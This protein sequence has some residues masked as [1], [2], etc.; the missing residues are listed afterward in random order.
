M[1]YNKSMSYTRELFKRRSAAAVAGL[2]II[3]LT[4]LFTAC[5]G[6]TSPGAA[7]TYSFVCENGTPGNGKATT[8]NIQLCTACNTGYVLSSTIGVGAQC[9]TDTDNDS[10]A[11]TV[12]NCPD[13]PNSDQ[14]FDLGQT[15]GRACDA[16]IDNDND[17]LIEIWTL[18]QLHNMRYDLA[19]SSYKTSS[20]GTGI[21]T[22]ASAT[23]PANCDDG[24][25]ATT[26]VLCGYELMQD[27]DFDLDGD[28]TTVNPDGTLDDGDNAVPYFVV[29]DGGWNPIGAT[30]TQATDLFSATFNGNGN[31]ISNLAIRRNQI[32]I[33]FFGRT[34]TGANIHNVGIVNAFVKY[35]GSSANS[36]SV[37][38]VGGLVGNMRGTIIASYVSG[39]VEGGDVNSND[40]GVLVGNQRPGSSVIASYASGN[41][42]GGASDGD[43]VGGLIGVADGSITASYASVDI[44]GS[45]GVE[46][47]AGGLVGWG[48]DS[49]G[50][51]TASYATGDV[52]GGEGTGDL[53]G[54]LVGLNFGTATASYGFGEVANE[55]TAGISTKPAGVTAATGITADNA[56]TCSVTTHT[57]KSACT[58]ASA[59]WTDWNGQANSMNAWIFAAGKAPRLRYADY[60]G[61]GTAY[62]C[63]QFPSGVTCGANG[64]QLPGQ[65]AQ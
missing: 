43:N 1:Y 38:N 7:P 30:D 44:D 2:A 14:G 36:T 52:D 41:A 45:A 40:I 19:G 3:A 63:S 56:G 22:G 15:V 29:S 61:A 28:G 6:G 18:E 25:A 60:D 17:G 21:T 55:E 4:L 33:A 58:G 49:A 53:A 26:V 46:D 54:A 57:T 13:I 16:D 10:V 34:N 35:I 24:N 39:N 31:T 27:L 42:N 23:E 65:P 8:E 12:D 59:T 62:A 20:A 48:S 9:L 47:R 51:I 11:D 50:T 32:Y 64:D 37:I 5:P